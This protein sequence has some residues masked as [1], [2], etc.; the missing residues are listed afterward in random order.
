MGDELYHT[1]HQHLG[2]K[3]LMF[4]VPAMFLHA[5]EHVT[6]LPV[7]RRRYWILDIYSYRYGIVASGESVGLQGGGSV[8]LSVCMQ[9]YLSTI[10]VMVSEMTYVKFV[11]LSDEVHSIEMGL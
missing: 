1:H 7:T 5:R 6:N 2:F 10:P 4:Y 8:C 3:V 11:R 9:K